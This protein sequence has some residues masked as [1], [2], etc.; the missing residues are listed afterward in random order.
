VV[1]IAST[2]C[3]LLSCLRTRVILSAREASGMHVERGAPAGDLIE[4]EAA[5]AEL[6]ALLADALGGRGRVALV[7]GAAGI[8]KTTLIE[9]F[10]ATAGGWTSAVVGRCDGVSTPRP[11]GPLYDVADVLEP[12][13]AASLGVPGRTGH[14]IA[15]MVLRSLGGRVRILVIED[16]HWADDGTL[17]VLEFIGRRIERVSAL[18]VLTYR[19]TEGSRPRLRSLLGD[20]A[21][22]RAVRHVALAPLTLG[23]VERL[24]AGTSRDP[25]ELHRLTGGNPFFLHAVL[26]AAEERTIP[27]T[28]RDAIRARTA[29]LGTVAR[30][31]LEVAAVIG[32]R[33][34]PWLLAAA[35]G[36]SAVGVDECVAVGLLHR[37]DE[38]IAF[39]HELTRLTVLDEVPVIRGIA[40]HRRILDTLLRAGADDLARLAYH[41]EGAADARAVLEHASAA[42]RHALAVGSIVEAVAQLR[43][44]LQFAGG[45]ADD[46]RAA[47]L[48]DLAYALDLTEQIAQANEAWQ[49]AIQLRRRS[50]DLTRAG[51]DLRR[52][53]RLSWFSGRSDQAWTLGR[54]AVALLEPLG[55][56]APLAMAY[57][58]IGQL[59]MIAQEA[60][61]AIAWSGRA[62]E[63]GRQI[64]DPDAM[65][66]ALN[67][68]GS[69]MLMVGRVDGRERLLESLRIAREARLPDRAHRALFNL[70]N[71]ALDQHDVPAATQYLGELAE[72]T[73]DAEA[74][75]DRN[76]AWL[77]GGAEVRRIGQR[78]HLEVMAAR[79]ALDDGTWDKAAQLVSALMDRARLRPVDRLPALVVAARLLIRRGRP[80]APALLDEADVLAKGFNDLQSLHPVASARAEAAWLAGEMRAVLDELLDLHGLAM[81]RRDPWAIGDIERWMWRAGELDAAHPGA[82]RPYALQIAGDWRSA[83]AA[84][85]G[86]GIPYEAALCRMDAD[87]PDPLREA[88]L[89]L[90]QLGAAPAARLTARRLRALGAAVPRGP[91]PTTQRHPAG[92]T[93]REA[94]VAALM[95][96]GRTNAEIAELLVLSPRTVKH[97]VSAILGKLGV[98]HRAAVTHALKVPEEDARP[99]R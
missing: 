83:A 85:D 31:A 96:E 23:G 71:I 3:V 49:T 76:R 12:A 79:I 78:R 14:D 15:P 63:L 53:S 30:D 6:D 87:E 5:L 45:T 58:N 18:V 9:R 69:A 84:W 35:S 95:A 66:H 20:L 92:L 97:H 82:A 40:L 34:E 22:V 65:S 39:E 75:R 52:L 26:T 73:A 50:G 42:G 64:G 55:P 94:E 7:H 24:V 51:D 44:A 43:R 47:M 41:A 70:T 61:A 86:L 91:R 98:S 13:A 37:A 88:H 10:V 68:I 33:M 4:R 62:L 48:E 74:V 28:V 90:T 60:D 17:D 81:A 93:S 8:G 38:A 99:I 1:G 2:D 89:R 67:N 19:D 57:S 56:S 77:T 21:T 72:L 29:G 46:V 59:H 80:G 11:F 16:L 27:L 54:E 32:T 36:E 25:A